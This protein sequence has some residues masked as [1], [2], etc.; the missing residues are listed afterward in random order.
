MEKHSENFK[1]DL[2]NKRKPVIFENHN[3]WNKKYTTENQ[4]RILNNNEK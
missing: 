2:E 4:Q 3:N 1:K